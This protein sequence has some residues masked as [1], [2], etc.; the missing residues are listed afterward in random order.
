MSDYT[1]T[2]FGDFWE[3]RVVTFLNPLP[4]ILVC[5]VCGDVPSSA[6]LLSCCRVLCELCRV[7]ALEG[8]GCPFGDGDCI[9]QNVI[10]L[11]R[12]L[13]H[14]ERFTVL[15]RSGCDF[16]GN[17]SQLQEHLVGSCSGELMCLMCRQ[18]IG[19]NDA[20]AHR[21]HCSGTV[22]PVQ[23]AKALEVAG[24]VVIQELSRVGEDF[25]DLLEEITC[26][27]VDKDYL[28]NK[29]N[30]IADQLA[31]IEVESE[32]VPQH[33]KP[34][35]GE[36]DE[37]L[38]SIRLQ[39]A[40]TPYRAASRPNAFVELCSFPSVHEELHSLGKDDYVCINHTSLVLGGYCF[41]IECV[42]EKEKG[43]GSI[44]FRLRLCSGSWDD[45]LSWPFDREVAVILSHPI[46]FQRDI[47]L[48]VSLSEYGMAKKPAPGSSNDPDFTAQVLW[49]D[50]ESSGF[51]DG[52][53]I[54]ANVELAKGPRPLPDKGLARRDR[55]LLLRLR[56]GCYRTAERL[57][58]LTGGGSPLC[59]DCAEEETLEHLL[60]KCPGAD[61]QR[62]VLLAT[63]GRLGLPRTTV[64]HLLFPACAKTSAVRA[65]AALLEF[66]AAGLRGRF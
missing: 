56:I 66:E 18:Y 52:G 43:E 30:S 10:P 22:K 9:K 11:N 14:L 39:L 32:N 46:D 53:I 54:Y 64:E 28:V 31:L 1:L 8:E 20:V 65:F 41:K 59:A 50:V 62:R 25:E 4:S 48:P 42:I 26:G 13:R 58:R 12:N 47:R 40:P 19:V 2:G 7:E 17:V 35:G 33:P 16:T 15:C 29:G 5:S 57:H 61:N 34:T 45:R 63:Y 38:A 51:V 37:D 44:H 23:T 55:S 49:K 36:A 60:L 21:Q 24:A 27:E 3:R 6:W